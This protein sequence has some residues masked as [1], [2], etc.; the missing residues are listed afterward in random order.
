MEH[1]E[2]MT[3]VF[4]MQELLRAAIERKNPETEDEDRESAMFVALL[5]E[6]GEMFQEWRGFK[7]WS[8]NRK[9]NVSED[10]VCDT[11]DGSGDENWPASREKL[12]EG[13][14]GEE[15]EKCADCKGTGSRGE[16]N[17]LLEETIDVFHFFVDIAIYRGY[18]PEHFYYDRMILVQ[19]AAEVYGCRVVGDPDDVFDGILTLYALIGHAGQKHTRHYKAKE[20]EEHFRAAFLS[21]MALAKYVFGFK[22]EQLLKA[23][24]EKHI[25]NMRR[26][27]N[28]Y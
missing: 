28:G 11:C 4:D 13:G 27:K 19:T 1:I 22:E 7:Y 23:Y 17:P 8:K 25:V 14:S 10:I 20:A 15:Y 5:Q 24:K 6:V 18:R 16:R 2:F 26:A 3:P 21:F 9:P 12:L